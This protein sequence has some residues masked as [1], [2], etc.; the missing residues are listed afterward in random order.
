MPVSRKSKVISV[1]V[2][3]ELKKR[4]DD[5]YDKYIT[6]HGVRITRA[7]F[8]TWAVELGMQVIE[9]EVGTQ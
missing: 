6:P 5:A 4:I 3:N 1:R 9:K 7:A 2:S 8:V